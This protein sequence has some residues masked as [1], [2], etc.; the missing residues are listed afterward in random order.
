MMSNLRGI[1]AAAAVLAAVALMCGC[2]SDAYYQNR[3]AERARQYLLEEAKGLSAE[4]KYHITFTDP[5]FLTAPIIGEQGFS[6]EEAMFAPTLTDRLNQICIAWRLPERQEFFMVYGASDGRMNYW[7]PERLIRKRF[8]LP[9][10]SGLEKA[11]EESR[12]YATNNLF[13]LM[14]AGEQNFI[15]FNFPAVYETS[16][17]LNL[18]PRGDADEETLAK[19]AEEAAAGIQ[20]SIVWDYPE[21]EEVAVFCGVGGLEMEAWKL[22]FAGKTSREDLVKHTVSKVKAPEEFYALFPARYRKPV[23]TVPASAPSASDTASAS[24]QSASE[25]ASA[26]APSPAAVQSAPEAA[27]AVAPSGAKNE[28]AAVPS[29]AK[30]NK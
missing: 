14:T 26:S 18:N 15:R 2:H 22:N 29:N 19:A 8:V 7:Y 6:K 13:G 28:A 4:E 30:E 16:F 17:A 23:K 1:A 24:A 21:D 11:T 9:K 10:A 12:K 3:A 25:T 5:V 20:Y 27:P